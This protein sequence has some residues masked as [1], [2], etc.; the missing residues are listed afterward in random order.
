MT[1]QI[2]PAPMNGILPIPHL[3][4][5]PNYSGPNTFSAIIPEDMV[6]ENGD[7]FSKGYGAELKMEILDRRPAKGDW[8]KQKIHKNPHYVRFTAK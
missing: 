5:W 2:K 7:L 4:Q 6:I 3:L 8:S 1:H